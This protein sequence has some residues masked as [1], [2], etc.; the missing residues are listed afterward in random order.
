[1]RNDIRGLPELSTIPTYHP[2]CCCSLSIQLVDTL[3]DLL[4]PTPCLMVSIGSGTG[5]LEA[6]LLQKH[7][8]L[9]IKAVEV[10][11]AVNKYMFEEDLSIVLG[12]WDLCSLAADAHVWL[13]VYPREVRLLKRYIEAYGSQNVRSVIWLGPK[14]DLPDC[15][16][17][18]C[19]SGWN[20]T[21]VEDC[22][23]SC[24]EL[25]VIW[26]KNPQEQQ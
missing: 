1:M 22:G 18:M 12:T 10:S 21:L 26:E 8:A 25:L 19:M 14:A 16:E 4:S 20:E 2:D 13:F 6:L 11:N 7:P 17:A 15:T 5:L 23:L 3:V 9:P 24:Y